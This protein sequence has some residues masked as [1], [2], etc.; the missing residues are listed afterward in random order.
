M[1]TDRQRRGYILYLSL[2]SGTLKVILI[3]M[4]GP[5]LNPEKT[6]EDSYGTPIETGVIP[7]WENE[8]ILFKG[9]P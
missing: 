9:R 1:P 7:Y 4:D 5:F 8:V 2:W 3:N 6:L